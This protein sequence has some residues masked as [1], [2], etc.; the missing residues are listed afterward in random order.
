VPVT[1]T[2][3]T[4]CDCIQI[5]T[6]LLV[7]RPGLPDDHINWAVVAIYVTILPTVIALRARGRY[8]RRSDRGQAETDWT[9]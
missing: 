2:V 4:A 3:G 7:E 9:L 6:S 1:R 8:R 5:A